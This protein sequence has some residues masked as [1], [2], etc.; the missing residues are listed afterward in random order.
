VNYPI[1]DSPVSI[2]A[3]AISAV[4]AGEDVDFAELRSRLASVLDGLDSAGSQ[5]LGR[6]SEV[7]DALES[8]GPGAAGDVLVEV[9]GSFGGDFGS[10]VEPQLPI[11]FAGEKAEGFSEIAAVRIVDAL[12]DDAG[13][14]PTSHVLIESVRETVEYLAGR[15]EDLAAK[16]RVSEHVVNLTRELTSVLDVLQEQSPEAA[17]AR[18]DELA[19][20]G[21][22]GLLGTDRRSPL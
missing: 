16:G 12:V 4:A 17:R 10:V 6:F 9:I 19:V 13:M 8:D 1:E 22:A 14:W 18:L 20:A 7:I 21:R 3:P 15:I 5:E 11:V 2:V